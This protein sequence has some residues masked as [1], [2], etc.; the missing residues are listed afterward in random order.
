MNGSGEAIKAGGRVIKNV[1]GFD[2]AKLMCG[3]FGTL[4]VLTEI[5]FRVLP[6]PARAAAFMIADCAPEHGFAALI[7]AAQFPVEPTALAYLPGDALR[8]LDPAQPGS[9]GQV[10]IRV[11]GTAAAVAEKLDF[12]KLHFRDCECLVAGQTE[13]ESFFRSIGDGA[14]FGTE[15]DL[16]RLCV[17]PNSAADAAAQAGASLW[18]ADWG[19]GLLWLQMPATAE[20]GQALRRIATKLGGHA[21]LFRATAAARRSIGVFGPESPLRAKLTRTLKQ[22]FDPKGVL[23][24]G[25]M[26]EYL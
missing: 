6:R 20:S 12:L 22:A 13:T 11:E 5:T 15:S 1:T 2:I 18:Y 24:P 23:N 4:G 17:P 19:G 7:K 21:T 10:I 3:A 25:K 9:R 8:Q 14:M 26:F 16:W